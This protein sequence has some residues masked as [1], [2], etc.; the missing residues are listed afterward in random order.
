LKK[1]NEKHKTKGVRQRSVRNLLR[2]GRPAKLQRLMLS[3]PAAR[4]ESNSNHS[5]S[6]ND[7]ALH[8]QSPLN[9]KLLAN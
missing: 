4:A 3:L 7:C 6:E 2:S 8:A 5:Y 1:G 9:S